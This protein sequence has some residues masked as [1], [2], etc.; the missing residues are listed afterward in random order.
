MLLISP[1]SFR[2]TQPTEIYNFAAQS[3]VQ[4]IF[5]TPEYTVNAVTSVRFN[6]PAFSASKNAGA[7]L[8]C[9]LFYDRITRAAA[10][11]ALGMQDKLYLGNLRCRARLPRPRRCRRHV[12]NPPA[13]QAGLLCSVTPGELVVRFERIAEEQTD[14][15]RTAISGVDNDQHLPGF[16]IDPGLVHA[17]RCGGRPR[18]TRA[19]RITECFSPVAST[20]FAIWSR[21]WSR[22]LV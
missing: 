17:R 8:S 3:N 13:G 6:D 19:R 1:V 4:V 20:S 21:T 9:V 2:R 11:I 12:D 18:R 22:D 7:I 14:L 16:R 5:E 15:G 10:A